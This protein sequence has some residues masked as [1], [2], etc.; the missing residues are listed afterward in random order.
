MEYRVAVIG[1]GIISGMHLEAL[2][3]L[4]QFQAVAIADLA[5]DRAKDAALQYQLN[6]YTNYKEMIEKENPDVVVI[7][8]PHF[9]HKEAAVWC[10]NKGCHILLEKPMALNLQ[11]CDDIIEAVAQNN[12]K[13]MVGHTQHYKAE[14][15]KAKEIIEQG[16]LGDLVMINDTRHLFYYNP[17]RPD[18]FFE[19]EKSG[20]G[21]LANFGAHSLDKI[22]WLT[23]SKVTK[24]KASLSY[25]GEKGN[26]EGSGLIFLETSA[27]FPATI[28]QSGYMGVPKDETEFIFTRGMMKI[29]SGKGLWV[30]ESSEYRQVRVEDH[31]DPFVLQFNDLLESIEKDQEPECS[32]AYAKT[33]IA[34]IESVYRS[35]ELGVELTVY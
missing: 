28:S 15:R 25:Y 1:A 33:I 11:E 9:L 24:V 5:E 2:K 8:L 27:G 16:A 20:G 6:P 30:S 34:A 29:I 19:K 32:G 13:L 26:V 10:A 3:E 17:E 14:N 35:H 7:A 22:Q 4:N 18:W 31:R 12:V 21:L 23:G